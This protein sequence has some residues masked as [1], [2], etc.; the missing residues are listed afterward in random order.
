MVGVGTLGGMPAK[1]HAA[2]D[3]YRAIVRAPSRVMPV[4]PREYRPF[5]LERTAMF[6]APVEGKLIAKERIRRAAALQP[7]Q[8]GWLEWPAIPFWLFQA[9]F[10]CTA[11]FYG[12]NP[13]TN[14][15]FL[16]VGLTALAAFIGHANQRFIRRTVSRFLHRHCPDCGYDLAGIHADPPLDPETLGISIGPRN[17]PECG[18]LW[19]LVP[20]PVPAS[21]TR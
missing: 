20:P 17:C 6:E 8:A 16:V 11:L 4:G 15:V 9:A 13:F 14:P 1:D 10:F 7:H 3:I 19:P 12:V 21:P 2:W 18:A 5:A